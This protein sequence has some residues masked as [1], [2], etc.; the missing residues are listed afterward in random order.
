MVVVRVQ[1]YPVKNQH[2]ARA[3]QRSSLSD[4]WYQSR[5][6]TRFKD[7][8]A[9]QG[10]CSHLAHLWATSDFVPC[11]EAVGIPQAAGVM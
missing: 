5:W 8:A 10:L 11:C 9:W 4:V 7:L 1:L 6:S 3:L 2:S